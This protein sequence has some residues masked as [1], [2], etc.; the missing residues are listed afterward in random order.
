MRTLWWLALCVVNLPSRQFTAQRDSDI[1]LCIF[2]VLY[3]LTHWGLD[4]MAHT[5]AYAI[6]QV[7]FLEWKYMNFD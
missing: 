3:T 2:V 1:K 5:F 7:H 4:N 6:F